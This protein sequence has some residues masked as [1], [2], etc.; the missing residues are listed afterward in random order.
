MRRIRTHSPT[1]YRKKC[2]AWAKKKAKERD[3]YACQFCGKKG[4][5]MQ[6]HGSHILPE[7]AYPLMSAEPYNIISLCAEHHVGGSN[8]Y[9][10]RAFESWHSHPLKFAAWFEGRWP[11]RF[12][13]LRDMNEEKKR[14]LVNWQKRWEEIK[15]DKEN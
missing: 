9:M 8:P 2:V 1:W 10:N 12:Q 15:H 5:G 14:H 3:G 11:G 7:G 4:T 13:E 6:I